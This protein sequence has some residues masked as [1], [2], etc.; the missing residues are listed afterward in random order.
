MS[1]SKFKM[2]LLVFVIVVILCYHGNPTKEASVIL[3]DLVSK[4]ELAITA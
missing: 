1:N 4:E 2:F 3:N